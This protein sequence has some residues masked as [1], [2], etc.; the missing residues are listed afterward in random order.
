M[1]DTDISELIKKGKESHKAAEYLLNSGYS[2]FSA[3]R[4]YYDMFYTAQALL[5]TKNISF[6]KHKGVISTFGKEFAKTGL[7]P[8]NLHRYILDAFDIRQI[9]DYGPLDSVSKEKACIL[10][11]PYR[12]IY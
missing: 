11:K 1:K 5:L 2:D 7:I 8:Y 4:S 10:I 9:G 3:S 12:R 6:S